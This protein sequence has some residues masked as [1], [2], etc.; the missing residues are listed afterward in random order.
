[1]EIKNYFCLVWDY[2]GGVGF[3][4]EIGYLKGGWRKKFVVVVL[5]CCGKGI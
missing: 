2:V 4:I 3:G 5:M 1:M